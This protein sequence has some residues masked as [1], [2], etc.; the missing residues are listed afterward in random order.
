M[1]DQTLGGWLVHVMRQADGALSLEESLHVIMDSMKT[2]YPCQ[3]VA[4]ILIDGDTKELRIKISRQISY[5]FVKKYHRDGPSPTAER[6]VLEQEP[7]LLNG[8]DRTSDTYAQLKLEHDFSSAVLAPVIKNKRGVGYIFCDRSGDEAFTA[9][10]LLHLQVV[11][12][13]I[14]SLIEKFE[15]IQTGKKLSQIDDATGTLQYKAFVPA[16]ATELE[17]AKSHGYA[18]S[19]ALVSVAAF[20]NYIETYGIDAAHGL[21]AEV[22]ALIKERSREMDFVGRFGADEFIVCLSGMMQGEAEEALRAIQHT[23]AE[24][25]VGQGEASIDI[26][27]GAL[28]LDDASALKTPLQ[29]ILGALGKNLV[30][31]KNEGLPSVHIRTLA[32]TIG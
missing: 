20:R 12:F 26:T 9:A 6:V 18:V 8:L 24:K 27:C 3:S 19:I 30:A 5:T 4:L 7:Q 11:G 14:G 23:V 2:Y 1:V 21:L 29:D 15:L 17:R 16:L 10:D 32:E 31:A 28:T 25:A 13:L 22:A